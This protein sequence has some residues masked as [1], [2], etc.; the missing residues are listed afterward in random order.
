VNEI[1]NKIQTSGLWSQGQHSC[2]ESWGG[3]TE[4]IGY[5]E[6]WWSHQIIPNTVALKKYVKYK[7]N[8]GIINYR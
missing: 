7:Y 2:A 6:G 8:T 5:A 4:W 3:L 1:H